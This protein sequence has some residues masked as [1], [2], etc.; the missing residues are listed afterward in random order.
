MRDDRSIFPIFILL[1]GI[2]VIS[3]SVYN[4]SKKCKKNRLEG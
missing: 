4:W 3:Y 2:G 1:A